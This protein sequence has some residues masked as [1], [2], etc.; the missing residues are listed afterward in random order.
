VAHLES[1]VRQ[2]DARISVQQGEIRGYANALTNKEA[3]IVR[4][5][6]AAQRATDAEVEAFLSPDWRGR[7]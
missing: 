3:I 5:R 6:S 4:V 2:R 1:E 7:S